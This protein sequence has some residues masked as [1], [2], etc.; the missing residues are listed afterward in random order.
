MIDRDKS[1][2]RLAAFPEFSTRIGDKF[3][4]PSGN[5]GGRIYLALARALE[6]QRGGCLVASIARFNSIG[7]MYSFHG[8][9]T[10]RALPARFT[11]KNQKQ[12]SAGIDTPARFHRNH[13]YHVPVFIVS[14]S[15]RR[16]SL[17]RQV[18]IDLI[19]N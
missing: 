14:K 17:A 8:V 12:T 11:H 16:V 6:S 13:R 15:P 2:E 9:F 10:F 18:P 7:A 19:I 5:E 3:C 4:S 1:Y